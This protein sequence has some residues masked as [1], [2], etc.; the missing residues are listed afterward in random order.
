MTV[1][2]PIDDL[3]ELKSHLTRIHEAFTEADDKEP[4][5]GF[6]NIGPGVFQN[7]A[8]HFHSEWDDGRYQLARN[9]KGV[10]EGITTILDSFEQLE[11]DLGAQL[12]TEEK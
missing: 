3:E 7:A 6:D 8:D 12:E 11:D 2:I 4:A 9:I 1:Y 10:K 5:G